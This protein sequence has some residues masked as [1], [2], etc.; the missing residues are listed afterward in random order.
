MTCC[1]YKTAVRTFRYASLAD[2]SDELKTADSDDE[3]IVAGSLTHVQLVRDRCDVIAATSSRHK[4]C[5]CVLHGLK[6]LE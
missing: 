6:P 1:S 3:L 5:R 2:D 4:A